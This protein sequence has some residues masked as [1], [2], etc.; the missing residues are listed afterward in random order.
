VH[1]WGRDWFS[2]HGLLKSATPV[3]LASGSTASAFA[4]SAA[5]VRFII[6]LGY[7]IVIHY[8]LPP[9]LLLVLLLLLQGDAFMFWSV[10]PDGTKQDSYSMHTGCP[11]LKGVKW[12]ATKWIHG[13]PFRGGRASHV[14]PCLTPSFTAFYAQRHAAAAAAP[15]QCCGRAGVKEEMAPT[16]KHNMCWLQLTLKTMCCCFCYCSGDI[17][18]YGAL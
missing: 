10:H 8:P 15:D 6:T 1:A 14:L 5:A 3:V 18:Q 12:T 16:S 11:V 4:L 17:Q 7:A 9:L 13:R 2:Q